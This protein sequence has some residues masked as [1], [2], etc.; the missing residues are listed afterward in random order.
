MEEVSRGI[1]A[2][3]D[4]APA[5]AIAPAP[6]EAMVVTPSEAE[7]EAPTA[8]V[9]DERD[10]GGGETEPHVDSIPEEIDTDSPILRPSFSSLPYNPPP[11][12]PPRILTH[13]QPPP[14]RTGA[15]EMQQVHSS[16]GTDERL[17]EAFRT[18][19]RALEPLVRVVGKAMEVVGRV[20]GWVVW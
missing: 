4:E 17:V 12:P 8:V 9:R 20:W 1:L 10:G 7:A 6:L 16:H 3:L 2:R 18:A 19:M 5:L 15:G 14:W 11:P 13:H